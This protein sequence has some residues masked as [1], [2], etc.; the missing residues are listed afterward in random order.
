M[1]T[2]AKILHYPM[3]K[4]LIIGACGQLG[5]ELTIELR[6]QYGADNVIASDRNEPPES[7]RNGP[8]ELLDATDEKR[9]LEVVKKHGINQVY[10]LVAMLSAKSEDMPLFAW[11]LNMKSLLSVLELGRQKIIQKVY[12][13]SSIGVFGASSPRINTPQRTIMEPTTVYGISKQAGE[14]WCEYYYKKYGV[15]TRSIRYPGLISYKTLPGGG[16][17]DYAVDIYFKAKQAKSFECFLSKDTKLPM[18]F[19]DDAV[20]GTIELM[21]TESDN[22]KIRSS[23]NLAAMSFTPE[24]VYN[25]ILKYHP[26]FQISYNSDFRQK[27]ADTWPESIDDSSARIDWGWKPKFDLEKMTSEMLDN[28]TE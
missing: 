5:S 28:I 19:M 20:R 25:A 14:R 1:T 27:I 7:L 15:D 23:Y 12:W 16:T 21:Q 8:F 18:M 9:L 11:D 13:P 2:F 22:V 24:M 17:T 26:G 10:H 6:K 4:I 3:D